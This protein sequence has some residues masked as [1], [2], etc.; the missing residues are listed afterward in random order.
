MKSRLKYNIESSIIDKWLKKIS[1]SLFKIYRFAI[2][3]EVFDEI[4]RVFKKNLKAFK[5]R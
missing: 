2:N 4:T 3:K 1:N 5:S